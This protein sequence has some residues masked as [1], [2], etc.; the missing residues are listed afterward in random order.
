MSVSWR[1]A[2]TA[3]DFLRSQG[4]SQ[5]EVDTV[6]VAIAL[7]TTSGIPQHMHPVVARVIA[8]FEMDVLGLTHPDYSPIEPD[9]VV[10][11]PPPAQFEEEIVRGATTASGTSRIP[12]SVMRRSP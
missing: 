7:H 10:R 1:M 8:G 11:A 6:G 4:I 3:R 2:P 12:R 9:V 5:Q